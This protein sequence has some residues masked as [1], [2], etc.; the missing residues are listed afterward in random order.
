MY[1]NQAQAQAV[2][3]AHAQ[4][5]QAQKQIQARLQQHQQQ[6]QQQQYGSNAPSQPPSSSS[7]HRS[8]SSAPSSAT[9]SS[10]SSSSHPPSGAPTLSSSSSSSAAASLSLAMQHGHTFRSAFDQFFQ[11]FDAFLTSVETQSQQPN[12]TNGTA[13]VNDEALNKLYQRYMQLELETDR[14][15]LYLT[16]TERKLRL[17]MEEPQVTLDQYQKEI[18]N[19]TATHPSQYP[20]LPPTFA[21]FRAQYNMHTHRGASSPPT[22][23]DDSSAHDGHSNSSAS[24]ISPRPT[25]PST[26]AQSVHSVTAALTPSSAVTPNQ[27][28][29]QQLTPNQQQHT[30]HSTVPSPTSGMNGSDLTPNSSAALLS[31]SG[32]SSQ[33]IDLLQP[34]DESISSS[35][36]DTSMEIL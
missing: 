12:G 2:A 36:L 13:A 24:L 28:A 19:Y 34:V 7:T 10:G 15:S 29:A 11:G 26:S 1:N 33:P 32:D 21:L 4:Q 20:P 14:L 30:S 17:E 23:A 9:G 16:Q 31:S 22:N 5:A 25:P 18:A 27:Q 3:A 6:Q 35:S 8:Q